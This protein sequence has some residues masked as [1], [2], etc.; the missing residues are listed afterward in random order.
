M[1]YESMKASHRIQIEALLADDYE[2]LGG[3]RP[4]K[5]ISSHYDFWVNT[6]SLT[7]S[8]FGPLPSCAHCLT[9]LMSLPYSASE[10]VEKLNLR[11]NT[12]IPWKVLPYT[13]FTREQLEEF[14][15]LQLEANYGQGDLS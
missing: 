10:W 7:Y 14:S 4:Y 2:T 15:R 13:R 5:N 3:I 8:F 1:N 9:Q 11:E 6:G 12:L